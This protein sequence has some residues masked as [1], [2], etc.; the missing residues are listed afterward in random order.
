MD[1]NM[2]MK[3]P[4]RIVSA[5]LILLD[6]GKLRENFSSDKEKS[7]E[8]VGIQGFLVELLGR[9]ELP[10]SSLPTRLPLF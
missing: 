10:T 9:F 8:S 3:K 5:G 1:Y 6:K 7:P 4:C 2:D